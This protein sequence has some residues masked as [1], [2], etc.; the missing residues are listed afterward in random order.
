MAKYPILL[1]SLSL[2][3][4]IGQTARNPEDSNTGFIA[5]VRE[6]LI[7]VREMGILNGVAVVIGGQDRANSYLSESLQG[8][9]GADNLRDTSLAYAKLG[10]LPPGVNLQND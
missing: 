3:G 10:L 2:A 7:Q 9:S 1:L 4:C 8:S 6:R 5:A